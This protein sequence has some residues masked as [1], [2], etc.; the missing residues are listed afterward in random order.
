MLKADIALPDLSH[1]AQ[2]RDGSIALGDSRITPHAHPSLE[3]LLVRTEGQ[4]FVMVRERAAASP[5]ATAATRDVDTGEFQRLYRQ[6]LLWHLDYV[7]IE[8]AQAG[9]RMKV[10][11][12]VLGSVPVY[13]RATEDRI[14]ISWDVTDLATEPLAIDAEI[15]SHRL[16][17]NPVYSA[18]Q[19]CVGI[20]LLTE[21]ACLDVQPGRANYRYPATAEETSP[22]PLPE[23]RDALVMFAELIERAVSARPMVANRISLELS[24]G[25]DS[26]SVACA[27]AKCLGPVASKGIL[28]D[29]DV[30]HPQIERR[31][32]ITSRLGLIDQTVEMSAFPPDLDIQQ[33][34][35]TKNLSREYYLEACSALWRKARAQGHDMLF[36]GIGGDELFPSYLDEVRKPGPGEPGRAHEVR[37]YAEQLLT[38][39]A[40]SAAQSLRNFDAPASPVPSTALLAVACRAPDLVRHGLWPVN[41]LSDP[42]LAAFCHRLPRE[43]RQG[44]ELIRQ[45]LHKHLGNDVFPRDYTKETFTGVM[46]ASISRHASSIAGQLRDCA[47]ADLGLVDQPAVLA[48]LETVVATRASAPATALVSFLWLERSVRQFH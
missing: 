7:M 24:G 20:Q 28:L 29:G 43:H 47:L 14:R 33:P 39:H 46:A 36:T 23:G 40:R 19:L 15:A 2:W 16:V 45:Y 9:C 35:Q 34:A 3:V 13:Y 25:M 26:G 6:C 4:W 31:N 41:P 42:S 27:L 21:R 30:R 44:R 1:Q 8:G 11:A 32:Q 17:M 18:R 12:G 10:R 48:L 5:G 22:T 38:R 37:H